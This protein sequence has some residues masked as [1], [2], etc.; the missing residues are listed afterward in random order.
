MQQPAAALASLIKTP[1]P[2]GFGLSVMPD[3]AVVKRSPGV[4]ISFK[5]DFGGL[6]FDAH[7]Y[8]HGEKMHI[9]ALAVPGA[10]PYTQESATR[11]RDLMR[12]LTA[13]GTQGN[14]NTAWL[15]IGWYLDARQRIHFGIGVDI[16]PSLQ[17]VA[18]LSELI[19]N[20]LP[21]RGWIELLETLCRAPAVPQTT[22][23]QATLAQATLAQATLA[24]TSVARAATGKAP[25]AD[26]ADWALPV[27]A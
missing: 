6:E 17:P 5:F 9:R 20:L 10:L 13:I 22:L 4:P 24:Q 16:D 11:R 21:A 27:S 15:G 3:G 19:F 12:V 14:P 8:D 1:V 23:A 25:A 2:H 7:A 18:V 26:E